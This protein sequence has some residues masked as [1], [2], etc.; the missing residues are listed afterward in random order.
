MLFLSNNYP[1]SFRSGSPSSWNL[2]GRI[3]APGTS[4]RRSIRVF[5]SSAKYRIPN[6]CL[7]SF[8][9]IKI[10]AFNYNIITIFI[11]VLFLLIL[12]FL[13]IKE[14]YLFWRIYCSIIIFL[15]MPLGLCKLV[16]SSALTSLC[17]FLF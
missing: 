5:F 15:Q 8:L 7:L 2:A 11:K 16:C 9:H 17:R 13:E 4:F 3:Q 6:Q 14:G 1:G 10:L 12:S